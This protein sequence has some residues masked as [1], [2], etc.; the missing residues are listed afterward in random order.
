MG[1]ARLELRLADLLMAGM[2]FRASPAGRDEGHGHAL[3]RPKTLHVPPDRRHDPRKFMAR[4]MGQA[5]VRVVP[6]PAMPVA[7]AQP[8][9]HHLDHDAVWR[10]RRVWNAANLGSLAEALEEHRLHGDFRLAKWVSRL[11]GRPLPQSLGPS[12][13]GRSLAHSALALVL[14]DAAHGV[15]RKPMPRIADRRQ[16]SPKSRAV[17]M[18]KPSWAPRATVSSSPMAITTL[19]ATGRIAARWKPMA[20]KRVSPSA[21]RTESPE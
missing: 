3:A 20:T 1:E 6:H 18:T 21:F 9:R 16:T 8:R 2:A 10:R 13:F 11:D 12:N 14:L 19:E 17:P 15:L 5:D 4:H 7:P